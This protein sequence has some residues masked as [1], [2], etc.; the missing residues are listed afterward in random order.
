[1]S[2]FSLIHNISGYYAP[3]PTYKLVAVGGTGGSAWD[4]GSDHDGVTKITVRTG[5][6]GVQYVKFYY[7]KAGQPEQGTLHGVHGSRGSTREIVINHPDAHLV[8]VEGWYDSSNVILGIQFKTNQKT[9]D[10]LGYES[11]GTGTK[12]TLQ[13][14][15]KKIIGFHGFASDHLNSIG[16][17]FVLLP[18]TTT[19]IPIVPP[20]KLGAVWD[21]GT[22]DKVK[23]F[24]L[25]SYEYITALSAYTK[26][27]STQ[28][29]VTSLTFTTNKKT[30][31]PYG[32]KSGFLFTFPE[33]TGKQIAGFHGTSGNVLNSIQIA[34]NHPDEQVVSVEGWYDSANVIS[35]VRFRTN[36][37]INDYM[38]YKFDGT[39]TKFTLK[40][41]DKKIIGF[42]GFATNQL[43]SLG[44]YFAPLSSATAPPIV[45]P[46]ELEA[47]GG[48]FNS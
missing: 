16:A 26:T 41:Q 43:I 22:H 48:D 20:K 38:G 47:K 36:Q 10:Y 12:F 2:T 8:S 27:L 44:A 23:K 9:S 46:K 13:D 35:G 15:D 6:V 37:N 19:T 34:I 45:T 18:S 30:Y 24:T 4:D 28:D 32:K 31:G 40:V 3:I 17:Y 5:G 1:M 14:K 42:H 33:E 7:V 39:G 25:G 29:I 11:E 21:D